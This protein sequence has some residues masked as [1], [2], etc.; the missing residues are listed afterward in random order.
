MDDLLS[1]FD[2]LHQSSAAAAP[3]FPAAST[4]A[5]S[6]SARG[7]A[8]DS[9]YRTS[10][11]VTAPD[12]TPVPLSKAPLDLLSFDDTLNGGNGD[13]DVSFGSPQSAPLHHRSPARDGNPSTSTSSGSGSILASSF[14]QLG[15]VAAAAATQAH[16]EARRLAAEQRQHDVLSELHSAEQRVDWAAAEAPREGT[17][18]G[19]AVSV[20][21]RQ[22]RPSYTG[23]GTAT[24]S[25]SSSSSTRARRPSAN[26]YANAPAFG[27]MPRPPRRMSRSGLM[28]EY[29]HPAAGS[30]SSADASTSAAAAAAAGAAAVFHHG[31]ASP[32]LLAT[33]Q[34]H[35]FHPSSSPPGSTTLRDSMRANSHYFSSLGRSAAGAAVS[36]LNGASLPHADQ[37]EGKQSRA[38][39]SSARSSASYAFPISP[40]T[41]AAAGAEQSTRP[42]RHFSH[43]IDNS[44]LFLSG[45]PRLGP[46]SQPNSRSPSYSHSSGPAA[47]SASPQRARASMPPLAPPSSTF[48]STSRSPNPQ[49]NARAAPTQPQAASA[50]AS[51]APRQSGPSTSKRA[52]TFDFSADTFAEKQPSAPAASSPAPAHSLA[53]DSEPLP[54]L[55]LQMPAS[56]R[57]SS[58]RVLSEDI[59]D[60]VRIAGV[61]AS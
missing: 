24:G 2:P 44:D 58:N 42:A 59:A 18:A 27:S 50:A 40:S 1:A 53:I 15:V 35:L 17:G 37:G 41:S 12:A 30:V 21:V 48:A 52:R 16:P 45:P 28:L 3:L 47:G 13:D 56:A 39:S 8:I 9:R 22:R 55:R 31:P 36:T 10:Q 14:A 60:G 46:A 5:S 29:D 61:S 32:T 43:N 51:A 49:L 7:G 57:N 23:T 38:S 19:Y 20:P 26:G 33:E 54:G 6:A 25:G 11:G 4:T 34:S